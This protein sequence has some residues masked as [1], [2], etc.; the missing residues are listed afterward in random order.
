MASDSAY[1]SK[2]LNYNTDCLTPS[3]RAGIAYY[4]V[5]SCVKLR[6]LAGVLEQDNVFKA[7]KIKESTPEVHCLYRMAND[8]V[9]DR[10]VS[11]RVVRPG[12]QIKAINYGR[13]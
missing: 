8:L 4:L 10:D 9:V 2:I 11:E 7:L 12:S 1:I 13:R 3:T 5:H 6:F